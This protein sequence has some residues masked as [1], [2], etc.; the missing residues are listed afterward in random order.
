MFHKE[1][2]IYFKYSPRLSHERDLF[3][4]INHLFAGIE[5]F[6]GTFSLRNN[7]YYIGIFK[8][9]FNLAF[10][11]MSL[12]NSISRLS[13]QR[14][15]QHINKFRQMNSKK[16]I[17]NSLTYSIK[18]LSFSFS[19]VVFWISFQTFLFISQLLNYVFDCSN[20]FR[21]IYIF[22]YFRGE[23]HRALWV[24]HKAVAVV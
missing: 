10:N 3:T 18:I 17:L 22:C 21:Y 1:V 24:L 23:C 9:I 5:S 11:A 6:A 16:L 4:L 13:N 12:G 20:Q 8:P 7:A 19:L 15:D 2:E 14:N